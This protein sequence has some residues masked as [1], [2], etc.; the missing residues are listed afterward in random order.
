[1]NMKKTLKNLGLLF[2]SASLLS[3]ELDDVVFHAEL[4][5]I[6]AA[7]EEADGVDV[8][9]DDLQTLDLASNSEIEPYLKKIKD[10]EITKVTYRI[11]GYMEDPTADPPCSNVIMTNGF[12]KFG[13]VGTSEEIELGSYAAAASSVNLQTTTAET[14]LDIDPAQFNALSDLLID[15]KKANIYS[16]GTLSCTPIKFNVV[17]K[18]YATITANA[19]E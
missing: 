6:F 10:V 1:M 13:E 5:I 15:K 18:F 19:I 4:E 14:E 16:V 11:T 8:A 2:I 3:C 12:A 9:Y 17:A 7:N